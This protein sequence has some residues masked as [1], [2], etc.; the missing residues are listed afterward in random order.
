[1]TFDQLADSPFLDKGLGTEYDTIEQ[2]FNTTHLANYDNKELPIL[3]HTQ[4]SNNDPN[5][6]IYDRD[7]LQDEPHSPM[8][9]KFQTNDNSQSDSQSIKIDTHTQIVKAQIHAPPVTTYSDN[10]SSYQNADIEFQDDSL[11]SHNQDISL[12][13]YQT[14]ESKIFEPM[15][16]NK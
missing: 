3:I 8:R 7:N 4:N 10:E 9:A 5:D 12:P 1:M 16:I 13:K 14:Q 15:T 6:Q 11:V 2:N